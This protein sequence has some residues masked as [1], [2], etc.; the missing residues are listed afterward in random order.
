MSSN[1]KKIIIIVILILL[2]CLFLVFPRYFKKETKSTFNN[3]EIFNK[4]DTPVKIYQEK[5]LNGAF[6]ELDNNMIP[7]YY[8]IEEKNWKKADVLEKWYSY[9]EQWWANV[10][11]VKKEYLNEYK[12]MLAHQLID[13]NKIYGFYVWIPRFE[14][15]LFNVNNE[16]VRERYFEINIV[17]KEEDKKIVIENG[18]YYTHPAFTA[19]YSNGEVHELNGFWIAKFEPSLNENKEVLHLPNKKPLVN[20]NMADMWNYAINLSKKYQIDV[21]S[22]IITNMEWGAIAYFSFSN[23]G[24]PGNDDYKNLDKRIYVNNSMGTEAWDNLRTGCSS[25]TVN[26]GKLANCKYE[27]NVQNKGTGASSTGNIYGIYDLVGGAWECVMGLISTKDIP[28]NIG[29]Y[30]GNPP[31]ETRYYSLYLNGS[32][33]NAT[34]GMIGD[35]TRETKGSTNWNGSWYGNLSYFAT[36]Q[37][38]WIKRGGSFRGGG[39]SG[40]FDYGVTNAYPRGDKTFRVILSKY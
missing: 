1:I 4:Q 21:P 38:P 30:K 16:L 24:K 32:M 11:V 18:K 22:R 3:I 37:S 14:Y 7:V 13:L 20:L 12:K 6:P 36:S 29:G 8:D 15:K 39:Y 35:A 23:Y 33:D 27:Y 2:V 34:R 5:E 26:M 31:K 9:K 19:T 10:V 40:L 17:S 25:G 28:N